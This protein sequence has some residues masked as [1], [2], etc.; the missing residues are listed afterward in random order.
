MYHQFVANLVARSTVNDSGGN[1][2]SHMY[3]VHV[4]SVSGLNYT[5]GDPRLWATST[6]VT[7]LDNLGDNY[8]ETAEINK[9]IQ[10]SSQKNTQWYKTTY[11]ITIYQSIFS[12][13]SIFQAV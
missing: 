1:T 5:I 8:K 10:T 3:R 7:T 9:N 11:T 13:A 12:N 4:T 2:N 6:T